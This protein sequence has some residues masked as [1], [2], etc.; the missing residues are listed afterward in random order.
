MLTVTRHE[1]SVWT[2]SVGRLLDLKVSQRGGWFSLTVSLYWNFQGYACFQLSPRLTC[3]S[4][5]KHDIHHEVPQDFSESNTNTS[6]FSVYKLKLSVACSCLSQLNTIRTVKHAYTYCR[7]IQSIHNYL[8]FALKHDWDSSF[9]A[10]A[11]ASPPLCFGLRL[12]AT[13]CW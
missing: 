2:K 8:C 9:S 5:L 10:L 11:S 1:L 3:C 13:L 7:L 6:K 4:P 12:P